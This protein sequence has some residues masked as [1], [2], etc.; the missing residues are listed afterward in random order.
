MNLKSRQAVEHWKML[1]HGLLLVVLLV[2][3]AVAGATL[4]RLPPF[5]LSLGGGTT[6]AIDGWGFSENQF[7]HL[8][9]TLGN[10]VIF[11]NKGEAIECPVLSFLTTSTRIVCSAGKPPRSTSDTEYK[12]RVYVDGV[13]ASGELTAL[14][15]AKSTELFPLSFVCFVYVLSLP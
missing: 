7:N 14:V 2:A 12:V 15:S 1:L 11:E 5:R 4:R 10:R 13:Q 3:E 8:N 6:V 9:A